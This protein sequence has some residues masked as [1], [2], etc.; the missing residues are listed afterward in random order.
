MLSIRKNKKRDPEEG[1]YLVEIIRFRDRKNPT[2][3][4]N[5]FGYW[6]TKKKMIP[7]FHTLLD[8]FRDEIDDTLRE[9]I[10]EILK[11][12]LREKEK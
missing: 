10:M 9:I 11:R 4:L 12:K 3:G 7:V 2:A 8:V 1:Q 6:A 5:R